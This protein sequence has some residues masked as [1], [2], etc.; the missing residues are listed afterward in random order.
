[1][2]YCASK[3]RVAL[4]IPVAASCVRICCHPGP[5]NCT[6]KCSGVCVITF[7]T[8]R[9]KHTLAHPSRHTRTRGS[10]GSPPPPTG[11]RSG[12]NALSVTAGTASV[13]GACRDGTRVTHPAVHSCLLRPPIHNRPTVHANKTPGL[14]TTVVPVPVAVQTD[15]E[16]QASHS[17]T[18]SR[19]DTH[20]IMN[21]STEL[22][23]ASITPS[24]SAVMVN[25]GEE[26][27]RSNP[28]GQPPA[29]QLCQSPPT[30]PR[31]SQRTPCRL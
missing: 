14:A 8:S 1:M 17:R 12:V 25:C 5:P 29:P 15:T 23:P 21:M 30:L 16:V 26:G 27:K 9:C 4:P 24:H 20:C 10:Y 28:P 13:I 6:L 11:S 19:N 2:V 18:I 31:G 3:I 7:A 22:I